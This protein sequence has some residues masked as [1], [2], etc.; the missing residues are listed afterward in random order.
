MKK[1]L[2]Y[3]CLFIIN[4][5]L[6]AQDDHDFEVGEEHT[7]KKVTLITEDKMASIFLDGKLVG[8]DKA[9]VKLDSQEPNLLVTVFGNG[10]TST[11]LLD[12]NTVPK[13]YKIKG[14]S[15]LKA[16]KQK[17]TYFDSLFIE[18]SYAVSNDKFIGWNEK[19]E[20]YWRLPFS[21]SFTSNNRTFLNHQKDFL[22][23]YGIPTDNFGYDSS[24]FKHQL[25]FTID[26]V[27]VNIQDEYGYTHISISA[28]LLDNKDK[29][30][31]HK[32]LFG[33]H[34]ETTRMY[35]F[36][37]AVN[38]AFEKG[39]IELT[40]DQQF[41]NLLKRDTKRE[42]KKKKPVIIAAIKKDS[43]ISKVDTI[44]KSNG[45]PEKYMNAVAR[46]KTDKGLF[47]GFVIAEAGYLLTNK[48]YIGSADEVLVKVKGQRT[49]KGKVL[50]RGSK[51][52]VV[53]IQ[54]LANNKFPTLELA[55]KTPLKN[56]SLFSVMPGKKWEYKKGTYE[57]EVAVFGNFY[58]TAKLIPGKSTDG[59]PVLNEKG[60]VIGIL[61]S[62]MAGNSKQKLE[63]IIPIKDALDD[64][65]LKLE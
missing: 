13:E 14:T 60:E 19:E 37:Q 30:I 39:I 32:A 20:L 7:T 17:S 35:S 4:S 28:V 55:Q 1:Y 44:K 9:K 42:H 27:L 59:T 26:E 47:V 45:Y 6:T 22:T 36:K 54:I 12:I 23:L 62:K 29:Q 41:I 3:F 11:E 25:I 16:Q 50:R 58:H 10:N 51:T 24:T 5:S 31:F 53:L 46:L 49:V 52:G 63:F 61:D 33:V 15:P 43:S 18:N 38:H 8:H 57:D 48:N 56:D 65:N 21:T 40:S 2:F 34:A 64:L